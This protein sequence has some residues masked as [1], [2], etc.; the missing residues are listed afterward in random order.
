MW[1]GTGPLRVG[2]LLTCLPSGGQKKG[3]QEQDQEQDHHQKLPRSE[4]LLLRLL[5]SVSSLF[6]VTLE[7]SLLKPHTS[8]L[9]RS[10]GLSGGVLSDLL[11]STHKLLA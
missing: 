1:G 8:C 2:P 9:I 6:V 10:W 7:I 4:Q 5:T 3:Q 11:R